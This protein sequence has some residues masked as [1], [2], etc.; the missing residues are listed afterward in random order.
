MRDRPLPARCPVLRS[1]VSI[2]FTVA[3]STDE[4]LV[5]RGIAAA[6]GLLLIA[7]GV[8]AAWSM[9][10]AWTAASEAIALVHNA[11]SISPPADAGPTARGEVDWPAVLVSVLCGGGLLGAGIYGANVIARLGR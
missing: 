10:D 11:G 9:L 1:G 7:L 4:G 6:G 8:A 5:A 3:G 2:M